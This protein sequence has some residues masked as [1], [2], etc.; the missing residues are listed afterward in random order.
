MEAKE[1]F[2]GVF[3][4]GRK[5]ATRNLTSGTKVYGEELV[6]IGGSEYRLWNPYRSKLAAAILLGMRGMRIGRGSKVLYLGAATGTTSSHVSDIVGKGGLVYCIEISER[7]M[8]ELVGVCESRE[9]MLPMLKDA[10]D[11]DSYAK[12]VGVCDVLYQ[13]IAARDQ[14]DI[15]NRNSTLLRSKG[16]AYV[17]IKSQSIDVTEDPE[18]VYADFLAKV[19]EIFEVL[20]KI[21]LKPYSKM[22]MFAVLRK[23]R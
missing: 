23:R 1:V 7:S 10:R 16:M 4:V 18:K 17:A 20:E 6:R 8:R 3:M 2:D 12:E 11:T 19:S 21:D 15:L 22:H 14:A 13:D 9:N 5:L